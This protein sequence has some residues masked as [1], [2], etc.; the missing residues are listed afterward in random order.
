MD[1][2]EVLLTGLDTFGGVLERVTADDWDRPTP[3]ARWT[4]RELTGHLCTVLDSAASTLRGEDYDWA[5]APD[6][7]TAAGDDPAA[8]FANRRAAAVEALS[9]ADLGR[10]VESPMGTMTIGTRMAFP[11]MDLHLHGWDLGKAIGVPVEVPEEVADFTHAALDPLP[12]EM[13]RQEN[14]FGLQVP[15]PD[16]ATPTE[17]LMAWTGRQPRWETPSS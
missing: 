5:G 16:D 11:A 3:C 1:V 7:G 2:D 6:P 12:P 15:A 13:M 9:G 10:E 14:V 8:T 17:R 4:V